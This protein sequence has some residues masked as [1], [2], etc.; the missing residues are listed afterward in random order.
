MVLVVI[1]VRVAVDE[2]EDVEATDSEPEMFVSTT[3]TV[4]AV[5]AVEVGVEEE[6]VDMVVPEAVDSIKVV[7]PLEAHLSHGSVVGRA[8]LPATTVVVE[9]DLVIPTLVVITAPGNGTGA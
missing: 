9:V 1:V 2:D 6:E 5:E 8:S 7:H 4:E 3:E